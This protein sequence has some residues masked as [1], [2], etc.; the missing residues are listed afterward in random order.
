MTDIS[1][2]APAATSVAAAVAAPQQTPPPPGIQDTAATARA[3]APQ[4]DQAV[5]PAQDG[6]AAG[7]DGGNSPQAHGR[8]RVLDI[9]V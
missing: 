4:T 9:E 8:G 2:V 6:S 1:T 5:A 3:V 7:P